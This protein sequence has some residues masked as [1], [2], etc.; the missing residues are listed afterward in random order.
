MALKI[1]CMNHP[2]DLLIAAINVQQKK[3][4]KNYKCNSLGKKFTVELGHCY[5]VVITVIFSVIK[6]Q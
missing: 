3:M 2:V 1:E 6:S 5:L 4:F